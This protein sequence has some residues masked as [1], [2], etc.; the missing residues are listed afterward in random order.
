[1][2]C[3]VAG[4]GLVVLLAGCAQPAVKTAYQPVPGPSQPKV[5][6]P[7]PEPMPASPATVT[8]QP[9]AKKPAP[10]SPPVVTA[11]E[12]LRGKVIKFAEQGRFVILEFPLTQMP[13]NGRRLFLYR[14][15]LKVGEVQVTG[16][17]R[18]EHTVADLLQGEAQAGD[19]VRDR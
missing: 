4:I 12:T 8:N 5:A 9:A 2:K 17:R 3:V 16:P 14:N 1:M 11:T 19:V 10:V 15:D 13:A 6:L 7:S 18:E